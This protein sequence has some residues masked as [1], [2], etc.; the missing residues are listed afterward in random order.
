MREV[1]AEI[2]TWRRAGKQIAIA[3]NAKKDGTSLR[4]LGAKM[5]MTTEM[6]IAGSLTGGCIEGAV[7]EEA[8]A[9]LREG[10]P[11]LIRYGVPDDNR[12][13]E[14]GLSCG[15]TLEVFIEPLE[16]A[17][18]RAVY[19]ALKTCLDENQLAAVATVIAGEGLGNKLLVR[20]DGRRVGSL[21][22]AALD[23]D[24]AVWA[25][26]RMRVQ[27]SGW[28][29]F[30]ARQVFVD[31]LP[32][33][34]R[35]IVIGA[36]HIAIPL[37]TLAKTLGFRTIVIDPRTAFATRERFPHADELLI[38]WPSEALERLRPD[39]NT[40]VAALSHDEKL[41]NPALKAALA[42]PARYV[43]VL[44]SR[45]NIGKRLAALRE[46][47]VT[48][49]QLSRLQAPIGMRLGAVDAEEIA[50]SILA[51]AVAAKHGAALP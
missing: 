1:I 36:V 51:A 22:S 34:A 46:L 3:M 20:S 2:E 10:T 18:W 15:S 6:D 35:L 24:A 16:S 11:R 37:V 13:W 50:L 41:D 39:E 21:G 9:V 45:K 19:P 8:Q 32:P 38:E 47:G 27:E 31:V 43:G 48:E 25:Q 17:G 44:G 42:S 28:R 49:T 7:Y 5:A 14:I 12:P 30:E 40:C 26:E 29:E 23:A 4:P 33:P